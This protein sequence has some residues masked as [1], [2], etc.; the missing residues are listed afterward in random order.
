M[1]VV[2]IF[3]WSLSGR[4]N[5][6]ACSC[7]FFLVEMREFGLPALVEAERMVAVI[8]AGKSS[9]QHFHTV[10]FHSELRPNRAATNSQPW[11]S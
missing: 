8:D 2:L 10:T 7:N 4:K 11:K 3:R 9:R 5:E 6:E 1:F